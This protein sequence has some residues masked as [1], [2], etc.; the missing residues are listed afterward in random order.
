MRAS[1][2][3]RC[4]SAPGAFRAG[5][6]DENRRFVV[7][8]RGKELAADDDEARRV[9]VAILDA[10]EEDTEVV[11]LRRGVAGERRS[12]VFVAC[13]ARGLGVARDGNLLDL[14]QVLCEPR[15]ALRE[16][17]RMRAHAADVADV[18]HPAQQVLMDPQLD[19]AA[20]FERRR[21]EHVERVDVDG[22]F[23]RVFDGRDAEIR[24]ARLDLVEYLVDRRHG[25]RV[26]RVAE[27][28]EHRRLR[29]RA[30]RSEV[31]D[32]ER[33][34]LREAGRHQLAE[35]PHHFFVA[36][37]PFVAL[38]DLAQHLRLALGPIELGRRA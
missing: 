26:H 10:V 25:Q 4:R 30:L 5:G 36:Q 1:G 7:A 22:A 19:L 16:R 24:R 38:D 21:E 29:E 32:L 35:Q 23:A 15:A 37:R 14:R 8:A 34:L 18:L 13:A 9:V 6:R 31:R 28:L 17:L 3:S 20:D 12:A 27:V 2:P 11:N 33:L